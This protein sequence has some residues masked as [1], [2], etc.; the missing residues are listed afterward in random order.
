MTANVPTP[1][2]R[3]L[4]LAGRCVPPG[5][6]LASAVGDPLDVDLPQLAP[7]TAAPTAQGLRAVGA[8]Y[9]HAELE[10]AMVIPLAEL[11]TRERYSIEIRDEGAARLLEQMAELPRA[12]HWPG[13]EDRSRLFGR[14]FGSGEGAVPGRDGTFEPRF[15]RLCFALAQRGQAPRGWVSPVAVEVAA[16]DVLVAVG[17]L[18]GGSVVLAAGRIHDQLQHA[19][20]LLDH[21]GISAAF[22]TRGI[23]ETIRTVAGEEVDVARHLDRGRSGMELLHWLAETVAQLATLP[24]AGP[25]LDVP[26]RVVR[27]AAVWLQATGVAS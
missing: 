10:Q 8:L 24:G 11:L 13:R 4:S 2:T 17:A 18:V 15:G 7:A 27:L 21:P 20:D 23:W 19:L 25:P 5:L 26:D 22:G 3:A 1:L 9:L 12:R 6:A 14:L 16:R